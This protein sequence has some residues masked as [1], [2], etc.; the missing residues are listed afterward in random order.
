MSIEGIQAFGELC[1]GCRLCQ[2]LCSALHKG[3]FS[4]EE[5]Y[6][7]VEGDEASTEIRLL[8]DCRLC[9]ACLK[10]CPTGALKEGDA[11]SLRRPLPG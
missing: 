11:D 2:L 10:V 8:P 9:S 4:P 7:R 6:I 3:L 5:A 1:C